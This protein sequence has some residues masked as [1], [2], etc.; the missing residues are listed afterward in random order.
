LANGNSSSFSDD[1]AILAGLRDG[2]AATYERIFRAH[3]EALVAFAASFLNDREHA[4]E[5][6][7]NVFVWLYEHRMTLEISG[8]LRGYL[9][10]AVRHAA[11]NARRSRNREIA[12][13][14]RM[15]SADPD[16][17]LPV[18]VLPPDEELVASES[19]TR[20]RA[21]IAAALNQL[22][23][24]VRLIL[25]LRLNRGLAYDEIAAALGISRVAAKQRF[26]R[27]VAAL[28]QVLP[29]VLE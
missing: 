12:R 24:Q 25:A 5:V 2:D 27:A 9:F 15:Q 18:T 17:L 20:R 3:Y 21:T 19:E 28:R 16:S 1:P 8:S 29:G 14:T 6:V 23:S 13:Y 7:G 26:S 10:G 11:L 22:P 4:E